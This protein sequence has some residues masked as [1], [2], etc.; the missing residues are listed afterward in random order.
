MVAA[1]SCAPEK[2]ASSQATFDLL[3]LTATTS[4]L[5]GEKWRRQ[6]RERRWGAKRGFDG[7][8]EDKVC[9][10]FEQRCAHS[11]GDQVGIRRR[12]QGDR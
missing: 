9:E 1:A 5:E 12:E 3:L 6:L 10:S 8:E 11:F 7:D 4:S 2:T